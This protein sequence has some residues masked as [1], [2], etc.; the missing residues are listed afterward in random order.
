[1]FDERVKG[2]LILRLLPRHFWESVGS[3]TA[4]LKYSNVFPF[5]LV[6]FVK[7]NS[8]ACV[9][10][11]ELNETLHWYPKSCIFNKSLL[12]LEADVF[13]HFKMNNKQNDVSKC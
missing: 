13:M 8:C 12:S 2:N 4:F 6:F 5:K 10:W 3:V 11:S 9:V 1:M 7:M